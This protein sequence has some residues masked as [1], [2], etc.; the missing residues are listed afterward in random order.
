MT[1][2]ARS[3]PAPAPRPGTELHPGLPLQLAA[4]APRITVIGDVILDTWIYGTS[5][6]LAREAPAPVVDRSHEVFAPG[7][8]ANTA[9]NLAALGA[10]VR[11][12]GLIGDDPAGAR[13]RG[14]LEDA[15][16][17]TRLL[18][19]EP[20][21]ETTTKSRV[22][23]DDQVLFRLDTTARDHPAAALRRLGEAGLAALEG[24]D[25]VV[26]CDYDGAVHHTDLAEKL[27]GLTDRPLTVI[28]AHAPH[29]WASA[30]PD[31]V[32][33]NCA[34]AEAVLGTRLGTGAARVD[35]V[36]RHHRRLLERTGARQ[37]VVTLD[38]DG[39]ALV[40]STGLLHRTWANPATEKQA[41]GAG[42]TFVAALALAR[43]GEVPLATAVDLAQAAADVVVHR[44]GTSLCSTDDLARHL[45]DFQDA[46]IPTGQLLERVREHR[47][48]GHRIILT[49]GCFDVLHRGHTSYLNKARQL[50]DVLIVAVNDDD[51]VRRLKGPDR[52]IN[53]LSD[54]AGVLAALSCVD[55]VTS[56][57]TDTPIPL[58]DELQ[59]DIYVKGG[60]YTPE[61]LAETAAVEAHG[62]QVRI[63]DYVSDHSTTAVV[64]R[65][66]RANGEC[67]KGGAHVGP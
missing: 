2:S 67:G 14:L 32:T 27:G 46:L 45:G 36:V 7:G 41:S 12:V 19:A 39:T 63:M 62:G 55:Y 1:I 65:M 53:P 21:L 37:V 43:A 25:T 30:R 10:Q 60:D 33:P 48:A 9:M 18:L 24:T 29:H 56:F 49:N 54:R 42:D 28:D 64:E 57:S 23:V 38:R 15:G 22:V 47:A 6:R 66:L 17:D 50:G 51:S 8:A 31:L 3:L 5:E 34:E 35:A 52:P 11:M 59:P 16:V 13:L 40:D 4:S 20:G 61:M 26:V 44:L 58:I